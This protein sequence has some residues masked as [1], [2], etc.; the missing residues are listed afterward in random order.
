M[1]FN[2]PPPWFDPKA[3]ALAMLERQLGIAPG[4]GSFGHTGAE[5]AMLW[6]AYSNL[7]LVEQLEKAAAV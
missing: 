2:E 5:W 1:G 6:L 4:G 7:R 3:E